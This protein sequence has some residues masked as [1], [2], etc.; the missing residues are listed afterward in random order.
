MSSSSHRQTVASLM[1]A[2]IPLR[3]T[4]W[5]ISGTSSALTNQIRHQVRVSSVTPEAADPS[6]W[7]HVRHC[8]DDRRYCAVKLVYIYGAPATGKLTTGKELE[9]R[10]GYELHRD[11]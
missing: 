4:S 3:T 9:A 1:L 11:Q 2:A 8:I 10:T 5:A 6:A 7:M